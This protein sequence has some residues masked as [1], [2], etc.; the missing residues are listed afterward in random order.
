MLLTQPIGDIHR[1]LLKRYVRKGCFDAV[2]LDRYVGWMDYT[3]GR[4]WFAH[5]F[6]GY[7]V[8]VRPELTVGLPSITCPTAVIWGDSDSYCPLATAEELAVSIP[9]AALTRI[10]GADHYVMEERPDEV[11]QA[12]QRWLQIPA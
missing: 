12:L 9:R 6:A 7:S 11:T 3:E 8:R 1:R 5:F 2:Q 10:A 4:R